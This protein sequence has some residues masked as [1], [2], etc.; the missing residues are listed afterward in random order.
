[1]P[2]TR[3]FQSLLSVNNSYPL[4]ENPNKTKPRCADICLKTLT[5]YLLDKTI[6]KSFGGRSSY[7]KMNVAMQQVLKKEPHNLSLNQFSIAAEEYSGIRKFGS[8]SV[9]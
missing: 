8:T 9:S 7:I 1:M 2:T 5:T 3:A 6:I 4:S